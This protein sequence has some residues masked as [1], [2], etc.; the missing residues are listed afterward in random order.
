MRRVLYSLTLMRIPVGRSPPSQALTRQV[1]LSHRT[2]TK[3]LVRMVA[4][5]SILSR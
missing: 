3:A 4:S 5:A 1:F 2:T